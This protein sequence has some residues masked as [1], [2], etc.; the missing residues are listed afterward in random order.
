MVLVKE[1]L[2]TKVLCNNG[3]FKVHQISGWQQ[4]SNYLSK[5]HEY[6]RLWTL[7]EAGPRFPSPNFVGFFISLV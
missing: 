3:S 7:Q 6:I 5:C 4:K 1:A 2:D